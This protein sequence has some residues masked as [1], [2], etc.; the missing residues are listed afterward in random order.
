MNLHELK[1]MARRAAGRLRRSPGG[2]DLAFVLPPPAAGGWVLD[3]IA[4]ELG[5]RFTGWDIAQCRHGEPLPEARRYFFTHYAYYVAAAARSWRPHG[6]Q[7]H[8]FVTH[9]EP[10]KHGIANDRLARLLRDAAGVLCMNRALAD[11]LQR[12]GVPRDRLHVVVGAADSAVYRPHPRTP[13]GAVGFCSAYYERK[14]PDM[15]LEVARRL[16]HRR[17]V[18]LGKGWDRYPRFDELR[19]LPNFDY[20]DAPYDTY[21]D[22]YARMS[23]FVSVSRLEGGPIPLL[24]AMMSNAVP[25]ASRTG[26]APDVIQPGRNGFLF[27]VDA[28]PDEVCRLIE[29]AFDLDADVAATV[30]DCDWD[31]YAARVRAAIAGAPSPATPASV[32]AMPRE[33]AR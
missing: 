29:Q 28:S 8:V 14:S 2:A 1:V 9:L 11:T 31:G 30:R 4:R 23:V 24:E 13:D 6:A 22:H 3:A 21:A 26:F 19:A 33:G 15:V 10:E 7:S 5:A 25:V 16:P 27:D 12:L 17:I 32:Q 18:L 20:I